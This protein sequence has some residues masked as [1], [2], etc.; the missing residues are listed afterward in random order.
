MLMLHLDPS[1]LGATQRLGRPVGAFAGTSLRLL[2]NLA[3]G[4]TRVEANCQHRFRGK[5][6]TEGTAG[7]AGWPPD[8]LSG[9]GE[10][11]GV[12]FLFDKV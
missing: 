7:M 4:E 11:V 2:R 8:C 6:L 3:H 1:L 5:Q 12:V 10:D 9:T